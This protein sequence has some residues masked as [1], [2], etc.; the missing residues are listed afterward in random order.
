MK[1]FS[2]RN[3]FLAGCA[4]TS[5]FAFSLNA[6]SVEARIGIIL[7]LTGTQAF[8]G[9][10]AEK[11]IKIALEE[12]QKSEPSLKVFIEDSASSPSESA[13]AMHKLITSDKVIAVVGDMTS[14]NTIAAG[15]I[16]EK[17][18]IPIITPSATNDTIT[19]NK[20]YIFRTCFKDSFQGVVMANF[21]LKNLKAK[22]AI[23]LEDSDSDY[24]RGLAENFKATFEKD[25]GKILKTLK[26]SQ[27]D[28]TF[29][30]QLGDVR[31]RKPDILFIPAYHQQVGVIIREAKDLQIKSTLVGTDGWNTP[32]L[33][34][35]AEG[36]EDGS[37]FSTHYSPD[38]KENPSLQKFIKVYSEKYEAQPSAFSALG[39]DT[40]KI[41]YTAIENAKITETEKTKA[42]EKIRNALSNI[43]DFSGVTGNI[44][45]DKN[46]NAIKPAVIL[47]FVPNGFKFVTSILP[48]Q[49]SE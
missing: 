28:T 3:F 32:E 8:Y 24:S 13:K 29:T 31:K 2:K 10:E 23:I 47:Q 21:S 17:E 25:G 44:T 27:K 9:K 49:K 20:K 22:T 37:Y 35:I 41:L 42:S 6:M 46:N 33:R 18:K 12:L 1:S 11:G 39:Y 5:S 4:L 19:D 43:K 34:K 16:A 38:N 26:F 30:A 48:Q 7:P 15:S 45:M 36:H 14:S 40:L